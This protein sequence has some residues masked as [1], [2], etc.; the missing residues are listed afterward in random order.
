MRALILENEL[1]I[2]TGKYIFVAKKEIENR[3]YKQLKK[4]FNFALKNLK[5]FNESSS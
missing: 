3:D 4:D 5:A 1:K 2:K